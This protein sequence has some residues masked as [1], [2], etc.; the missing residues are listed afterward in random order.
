MRAKGRKKGVK[1]KGSDKDGKAV[2]TGYPFQE[3]NNDCI[4][5]NLRHWLAFIHSIS[6]YL[7]STM[8]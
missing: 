5:K 7:L 1:D 4:G 6:K 3:F 8:Y 2:H